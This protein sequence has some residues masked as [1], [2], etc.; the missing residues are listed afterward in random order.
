M[1]PAKRPVT[2]PAGSQ[3]RGRFSIPTDEQIDDEDHDE[4]D[5]RADRRAESAASD[6]V[7]MPGHENLLYPHAVSRYVSK[8]TSYGNKRTRFPRPGAAA[9]A[10]A[11]C[12][13]S[14]APSVAGPP[15]RRRMRAT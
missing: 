10:A 13:G 2:I 7:G 12:N 14:A 3:S 6:A 1:A 15:K 11:R 9:P 5:D 8:A 4:A